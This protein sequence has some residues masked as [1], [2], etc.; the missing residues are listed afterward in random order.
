VL[1]GG[2]GRRGGRVR[3]ARRGVGGG[4]APPPP[5]ITT[6][7]YNLAR[8]KFIGDLFRECRCVL[9]GGRDAGSQFLAG[10]HRRL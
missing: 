5:A 6:T 8:S 1:F 2:L 7:V 4:G 9:G 3:R 10:N